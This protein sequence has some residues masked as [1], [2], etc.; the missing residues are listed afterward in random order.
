LLSNRL[1][2]SLAVRAEHQEELQDFTSLYR[3]NGFHSSKFL[4]EDFKTPVN[5]A[6]RAI[7]I[8]LKTL[9]NLDRPIIP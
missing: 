6:Q 2:S 5:L 8:V 4:S 9:H 7:K 3:Q 1:P